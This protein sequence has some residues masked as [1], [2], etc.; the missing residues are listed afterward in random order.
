[1]NEDKYPYF[2]SKT[3]IMVSMFIFF[4][5]WYNKSTEKAISTIRLIQ[6]NTRYWKVYV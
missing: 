3:S 1:M 6:L 2:V 4:Q 5:L